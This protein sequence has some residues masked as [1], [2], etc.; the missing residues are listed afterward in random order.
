MKPFTGRKVLAFTVGAFGIIIAVNVTM[1][2]KA[3]STF[4]GLEVKNS[5]VASQ[6]FDTQREAQMALGW[7]VSA[8]YSDGQFRLSILGE[9][10]LPIAVQSL[11]GILGRATH[12]KDDIT[13]DFSYENGLYVAAA[14]L[15]P[16]NWNL[17]MLAVAPDGTTFQQRVVIYVKPSA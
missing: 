4:P 12:V 9:D 2:V 3:I 15:G 6:E 10:G 16:G 7:H 17:R 14:D 13:P 5:Y 8:D 1:A 11:T